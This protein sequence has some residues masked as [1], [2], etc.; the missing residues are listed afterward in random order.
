MSFFIC[1]IIITSLS[2]LTTEELRNVARPRN[3]DSCENMSR[4][5][6]KN[7]F[8]ASLYRIIYCYCCCYH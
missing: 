1:A 3:V 6:L 7:I 8:T 2:S 4:Q 5:Q